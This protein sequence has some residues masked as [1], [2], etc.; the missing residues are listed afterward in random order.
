MSVSYSRVT[1]SRTLAFFKEFPKFSIKIVH[2]FNVYPFLNFIED[3]Y[4]YYLYYCWVEMMNMLSKHT[5]VNMRHNKWIN[6]PTFRS[7]WFYPAVLYDTLIPVYINMPLYVENAKINRGP[8]IYKILYFLLSF[9]NFYRDT[10]KAQECQIFHSRPT[11]SIEKYHRLNPWILL[12]PYG[13]VFYIVYSRPQMLPL[14]Y[15]TEQLK[16]I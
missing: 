3:L 12:T 8:T 7:Y 6:T 4:S 1:Y 14:L 16:S 2:G 11:Y 10:S 15:T 5:G 13:W 9:K